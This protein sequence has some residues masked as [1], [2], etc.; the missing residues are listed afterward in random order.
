M[1][2][3]PPEAPPIVETEPEIGWSFLKSKRWAGYFA[4]LAVFSVACAMFGNW[5]FDRRAEARAEIARIDSNYDAAPVPL[6]DAVPELA[7]FDLDAHKWLP[8]SMRGEYIGE[9]ILARGRPGPAGVGS[10]LIN[11]FRT[12]D[13]RVIFVDRGWVPLVGEETVS[14]SAAALP[15]P[16]G[17]TVEVEGR[18][19]AG[20][21]SVPGRTTDG[22]TVGSIELVELARITGVEGEAYTGAYAMLVSE[23]PSAEHGALPERPER[24]EG[25]H[26]SYALQWYI[27]IVIACLGVAYAARR[28]FRTLNAGGAVVAEQDRRRAERKRRRGPS[29]ADEEDALLDG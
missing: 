20:E 1:A 6:A 11:A 23:Q 29:D 13:G 21:P 15:S 19:R 9:T 10:D 28:E 7:D 14:G 18:L 17:G 16:P 22:L 12:D 5:Q 2:E 4:L 25:P 26:L 24:D 8:V 27:F 3:A